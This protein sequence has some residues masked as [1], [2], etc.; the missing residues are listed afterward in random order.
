MAQFEKLQELW[1][2]QPPVTPD[3]TALGNALARYGRRREWIS[4]AKVVGVVLIIAWELSL[5]HYS[6][7]SFAGLGMLIAGAG[8][9]LWIEWRNNRALSRLN[10]AAPPAAFVRAAI[11]SLTSQRDLIRKFYWPFLLAIIAAMLLMSWDGLRTKPMWSR[12]VW[13]LIDS[14]VSY[15]AI[16]LGLRV[17]VRRFEKQGRPLLDRLERMREA[18]EEERPE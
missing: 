8:T 5:I 3:C 1:Q 14:A 9:V 11:G 15:G 6:V 4:L 7:R 16:E 12:C 18:L 13:V 2:Q 10:F 17:R